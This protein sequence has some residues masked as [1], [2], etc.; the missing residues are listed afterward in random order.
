ML[1]YYS[2][3]KDPVLHDLMLDAQDVLDFYLRGHLK[4]IKG[5]STTLINFI[6]EASVEELK[7]VLLDCLKTN[8]FNEPFSTPISIAKLSKEL[9]SIEKT[10]NVL[11]LCS[12][13]GKFLSLVDETESSFG[14]DIN[15]GA[16][17]EAYVYCLLH[18]KLPVIF[19]QDALTFKGIK[20]FEFNKI[21]CH[22]PWGIIY[23]RPLQSLGC[24][25][26]NPLPI[27]DL[28]R[29]MASWLFISKTLSLLDKNGVAVVYCNDGSLFST[30]EMDIRRRA[31]DSGLIKG[32]IALPQKTNMVTNVSSSL[33]VLSYGNESIRFVDATSFGSINP[34]NKCR[35]FSDEEIKEIINLFNSKEESSKAISIKNDKIDEPYLNVNN[36]LN[37]QK[38][39]VT[40]N[41]G[42]QIEDILDTLVKSVVSKSSYLTNDS[43]TGIKVL[44]SSDI[45]DGFVDINTLPYLSQAGVEALPRNWK[46]NIL[47]NG[48]V[49]MTNKSTVIKSAVVDIND[50]KV[51]LFGSLYGL[52][53][54]KDVMIP[55]YLSSFINSNAGQLLLRT[56]QTGTIISM[57][58]VSNFR[59]LLV[60]CPEI[61]E[62]VKKCEEISST[63]EM[64]K[65]SQDRLL[66]LKKNY[67]SSFD[68]L[69]KEE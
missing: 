32:V 36:Y 24:E 57:I 42:K 51:I 35:E 7:L 31:I 54:K 15:N 43:T 39:L 38:S 10:D 23:D 55:A 37:P 30:Y 25:K 8:K 67:E 62:Q 47:K 59:T 49:V 27:K 29:S 68:E 6:N 13:N 18:N 33:L 1:I 61:P 11:D 17:K 9:L 4:E 69:L 65:E 28:K 50:E 19:H 44:S 45:K 66:K 52:R 12:G 26:W 46:N 3:G 40:F 58:T 22:Y 63:L 16:L 14:V 41:N 53:V 2:E 21:F 56:I 64:I 20:N 5:F 48:D 34:E 60:P